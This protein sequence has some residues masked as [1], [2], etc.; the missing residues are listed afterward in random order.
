MPE[1]T[2]SLRNLHARQWEIKTHP[3]K[4]K[5]VRAGRRGGKTTLAADIAVDLFLAGK[6]ILYGVPTDDQVGRFWFECKRALQEPIEAGL[7]SKN[8]TK[9]IIELPGTEQRIRA[10]TAWNADTLRG[11][12]GD[13]I[14]LD[15]FQM[16]EADTLDEVVYP[17]LL[18]NNGDLMLIYT[19]RRG[20][21]GKYARELF[22]KG[23]TDP[24]WASFKFTSHDNPHISAEA[25][26]EITSDMTQAAYR[27]EILAE[28]SGDNPHALWKREMIARLTKAPDLLR[29]VVGVDPPG[30]VGTECGI[31]AAGKGLY[32]GRMCGF[33]LGDYSRKGS[34]GEWGAEAVAAYHRFQADRMAGE[35]NYGGDMVAHTIRTVP[36]G[37]EV[38]YKDV[39]ATRGK[40]VRAEPIA[41]LYEQGLVY[42]VGTF[43][44]LED[45]MCGYVP[46]KGMPSPNRYDA[47]VWALTELNLIGQNGSKLLW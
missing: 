30:S 46:D 26:A 40:A 25:L 44:G 6:R 5:V 4:R 11:D 32:E 18:D 33:V 1:L 36:N 38:A 7:F 22:A 20:L 47:L 29:V 45:E 42:H 16:M 34:P 12:Y 8:E 28:E 14:I 31:V 39:Q 24:R 13:Y 3:A 27:A 41:A 9:H 19:E 17:M 21:K 43:G 15:E 10:K 2:I 35:R 37:K 23:D